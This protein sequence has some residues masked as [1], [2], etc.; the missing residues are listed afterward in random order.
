MSTS[1]GSITPH[2]TITNARVVLPDQ[3]LEGA[4]VHIDDGVIASVTQGSPGPVTT[5]EQ[6]VDAD[7]AYLMP[8][9]IDLHND[10]L[11]FEVNPRANANLPLPFA[12]SSMERRLAGAGVTT[13]FHAISFR[14]R[15]AKGRSVAG[16][17]AKAAYIAQFDDDPRH[18]V[19]HHILHRLDVR[20]RD[21]L[22]AALPSLRKVRVPYI[23][24]DDHSPG[25]GQYRDVERLIQLAR[26]NQAARHSEAADPDW[27]RQRMLAAQADGETVPAFYRSVAEVAATLPLTI[28]THDDD[29]VEKVDQQLVLGAG[30]AEFPVT[31]EAARHAR[32]HGMAIVVGAPNVVRGGSQSGNLS[33][34]DLVAEGLADVICA[35]YH[36]PCLAPAAFRLWRDGVLDLPAAIRMVPLNPA[37]AVGLHDRGAIT[38]GLAADLAIVRLDNDGWPHVEATFVSGR[39]AFHFA[40]HPDLVMPRTIAVETE[41][42]RELQEQAV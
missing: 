39:S 35:D 37:R 14:D 13:E 33:A 15:P 7:G 42:S 16:A 20:S 17:E 5:R 4:T 22:D 24:L 34:I 6:V 41:D 31:F 36:A 32:A 29:T 2:L 9:I 40:R 23:S 38:P 10:N 21:S 12:L 26:Q 1:H 3:V 25:Q 19:R 28:A 27:Y 11:E 30:I 8:G 18:G